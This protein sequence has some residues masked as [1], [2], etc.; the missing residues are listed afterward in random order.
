MARRRRRQSKSFL[1]ELLVAP[2]Q[3]SIVI[4]VLAFIGLKWILPSM[5]GSNI[6]LKP[7]AQAASGLA[8]IASGF[9]FLIGLAV[10]AKSAPAKAKQMPQ[11]ATT[12]TGYKPPSAWR[13]P[14]SSADSVQDEKQIPVDHLA[15]LA[16]HWQSVHTE[17]EG[18]DGQVPKPI[19]WSINVI[20]DLEW[21]R[22]EDVCQRFYETKGIKCE[23]TALGPDGG[24]D[25]R[26]YQDDT[27]QVTSIVQCKAWGDRLV[28]VKPVR[29]LLG[30]MTH[31]KIVKAFFMT[32]GRFSEDAKAIAKSNRIT[33]IDGEMLLAMLKRLPDVEQKSLLEF[34]TDGDY[35]LPTCPSCGIKMK[36]VTGKAGR[37]DF[38]GCHN[39][40]RCRQMLGMRREA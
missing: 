18:P 37:A 27:G 30:V 38:W 20:R 4:G 8:W 22:F 25:I 7:I 29:E 28:G 17:Q 6:F 1:D 16:L 34:A 11:R 39:Y 14:T 33:L 10:F 2:W 9:F 35:K 21:K 24:I 5:F 23:T 13:E 40:P 32:S 3:V 36:R 26:L 12:K 19:E 31:E 15:E